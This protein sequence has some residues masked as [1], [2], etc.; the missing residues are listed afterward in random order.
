MKKIFALGMLSLFALFA[1]NTGPKDLEPF[2]VDVSEFKID[3]SVLKDGAEVEILGASGN[4]SPEHE[5]DFYILYVVKSMETGDTINVLATT[6]YRTD[7]NPSQAN[8]VSNSSVMGKL[9]EH[10]DASEKL[11]GTNIKDLKAKKFKKV[12]YDTEFIDLDVRKFPA[13]TG[14]LGNYSI[15]GNLDDFDK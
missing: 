13:V 9:L 4:L 5:I 15:E 1:C 12:F 3:N 14:S 11:Q 8:F 7:L 10:N 2:M 6:F